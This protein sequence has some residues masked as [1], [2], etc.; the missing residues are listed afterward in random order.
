ME[1]K[2]T[3]KLA[4]LIMTAI[5][6]V[7]CATGEVGELLDQNQREKEFS[8]TF[9]LEESEEHESSPIEIE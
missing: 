5:G 4:G 1:W 2:K 8:G 3:V 7:A 6:S 9:D